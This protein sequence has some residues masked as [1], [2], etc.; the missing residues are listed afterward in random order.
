MM[1]KFDALFL[2]LFLLLGHVINA[3]E[4]T[5]SWAQH[6]DGDEFVY[7]TASISDADGNIYTTG[8]FQ[9]NVD[10]D[11]GPGVVSFSK[12]SAAHDAFITKFD[13]AGNFV[14]AKQIG[15]ANETLAEA[16]A[17]DA[18]GNVYIAGNYRGE[19]D[20]DPG[21]SISNSTALANTDAFVLKLN[22]AGEFLWVRTTQGYGNEDARSIKLDATGQIF[23]T[24][25]FQSLTDFDPG[26]GVFQIYA[27]TQG[28]YTYV[29]KLDAAGNFG[30]AKAMGTPSSS[31]FA[32]GLALDGEGNVYTGG[33]FT[34][35]ADFDPGAGTATHTSSSY[36]V[37]V[38]KLNTN[39]EYVW[40]K[41][42][43][44]SGGDWGFDLAIDGSGNVLTTGYFSGTMDFDP[45]AG[46]ALLTA[47]GGISAFVLK[48]NT[49]GDYV[50][51]R[52]VTGGS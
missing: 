41:S 36:D 20:F 45:G 39:G 48:L 33:T 27:G 46:E 6:S 40:S 31:T 51:A 4:H 8:Y 29:L 50:W 28:N 30:W 16:I 26:T 37:Y 44:G 32:Y 14:W 17:V 7:S 38:V 42:L 52:S 47:A 43:G 15:G 34:G 25:Y 21:T 35:T 10:F 3:Q 13:A 1:R 23:L 18:S 9:G 24:G 49:T 5:F 11:P 2:C 22:P 19:V 12:P